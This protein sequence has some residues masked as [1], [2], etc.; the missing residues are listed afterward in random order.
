MEFLG[1]QL[2]SQASDIGLLRESVRIVD[3]LSIP[4]LKR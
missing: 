4:F 2:D 1:P 3:F